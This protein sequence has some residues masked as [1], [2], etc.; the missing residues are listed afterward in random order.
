MADEHRVT[1][2]LIKLYADGSWKVLI[3]LAVIALFTKAKSHYTGDASCVLPITAFGVFL[4]YILWESNA[5]YLV[6]NVFLILILASEG[7][8]RLKEVLGASCIL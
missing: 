5:R 4:F 8:I 2:K 7:L 3:L 6:C 1:G